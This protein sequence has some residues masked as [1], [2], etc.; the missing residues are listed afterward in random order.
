MAFSYR[1]FEEGS[2]LSVELELPSNST[3]EL[4]FL[5]N[6]QFSA[7]FCSND[8]DKLLVKIPK[9]SDI[10]KQ[11]RDGVV[12][13]K[14]HHP[15]EKWIPVDVKS[16]AFYMRKQKSYK[17]SSE[18]LV[19]PFETGCPECGAD[20]THIVRDSIHVEG[21]ISCTSCGYSTS[22]EISSNPEWHAF[23]NEQYEKRVRVG[24]PLDFTVHDMGLG[25]EIDKR[26]E[27]FY[28][29]YLSKQT[30]ALFGRLRIQNQRSRIKSGEDKSIALGFNEIRLASQRPN[31]N[32]TRPVLESAAVIYRKAVKGKVNED[33]KKVS[34]IRGRSRGGVSKAS[35]YIASRQSGRAKTLQEIAG[36][37]NTEV[38]KKDI[39][40]EFRNLYWNLGLDPK[41][42]PLIKHEE[43]I[44]SY[45]E[46]LDA[47]DVGLIAIKTLDA[48]RKTK[49]PL[50]S[51]RGPSGIAGAITYIS[52]V[53]GGSRR[54]Q[55]E[56]A[57]IA[58]VTEVT[59][60]NRY[61]E[62]METLVFEIKL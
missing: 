38:K 26:N 59:I 4:P 48:A 37:D 35:L 17:E 24:A 25:S 50:T 45:L 23:D 15:L 29:R 49:P 19:D 32:I 1:I 34:Y 31:M 57:E 60:R 53:L 58:Q 2:K 51:G 52:S 44:S 43:L 6:Y 56:I 27:D 54:T 21:E 62:L 8:P 40:R 7:E 30:S 10:E 3:I 9:N 28:G 41:T 20:K 36:E 11:L 14:I 18:E 46:K 5:N 47:S 61:K 22:K 39:A 12:I 16:H 42:I 33:G 55:R 13:D